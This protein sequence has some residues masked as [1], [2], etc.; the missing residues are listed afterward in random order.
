M[1]SNMYSKLITELVDLGPECTGAGYWETTSLD[2]T[3]MKISPYVHYITHI[4]KRFLATHNLFISKAAAKTKWRTILK[5]VY[6]VIWS[7]LTYFLS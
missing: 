5:R 3:S 2:D 6:K 1:L 7:Y 4:K